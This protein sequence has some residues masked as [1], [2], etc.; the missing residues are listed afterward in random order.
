MTDFVEV[1]KVPL[2]AQQNFDLAKAFVEFYGLT[3][4]YPKLEKSLFTTKKDY[5][6]HLHKL[7]REQS[8]YEPRKAFGEAPIDVSNTPFPVIR[9]LVTFVFPSGREVSI[10]EV[11]DAP[12]GVT[13]S[14]SLRD[15]SGEN[16]EFERYIHAEAEVVSR[17]LGECALEKSEGQKIGNS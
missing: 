12:N 13:K 5:Q 14:V 10:E 8:P 4:P 9:S 15:S 7:L 16:K 11:L 1:A 2:S 17:F 3:P 6:K